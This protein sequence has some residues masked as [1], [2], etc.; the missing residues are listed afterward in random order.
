M[1][2]QEHQG[3]TQKTEL[4]NAFSLILFFP[5]LYLICPY[6]DIKAVSCLEKPFLSQTYIANFGFSLAKDTSS[7]SQMLV[8]HFL[9]IQQWLWTL[10]NDTQGGETDFRW[11]QIQDR[12]TTLALCIIRKNIKSVP[13]CTIS[14]L[15]N[16]FP[17]KQ[18]YRIKCCCYLFENV[19]KG[20][21][22]IFKV[23]H[24]MYQRIL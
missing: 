17:A 2:V 5:I 24:S 7:P 16:A 4:R 10:M 19:P 12:N 9:S 23:P 1:S 8:C 18:Y 20:W 3:R 22:Q 11:H 13:F 6:T 15:R 14:I 21:D